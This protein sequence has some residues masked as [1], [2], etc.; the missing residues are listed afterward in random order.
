MKHAERRLRAKKIIAYLKNKYPKAKSEL[1]YKTPY[2]FVTAVILSARCTD[3]AVNK[4]TA[5]LFKKYKTVRNF[6]DANP[7]LFTKE[8]SSIPFYNNKTKFIIRA[9]KEILLRYDGIVPRT[10]SEL[11]ALPGIG[12][13]TA[14]VILGELYDMWDGIA[15]DTHVKRFARRFD[16]TD[17]TDPTKISKD[18]EILIPKKDWKYVNAGMVL[19]GRYVC[20]AR[21]H[22]CREHPLTK[23]WQPVANRWSHSN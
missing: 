14:N 23:L 17:N 11:V 2:Q 10:V 1:Q 18:L 16:L 6:A 3:K 20:T 22:N 9:A 5:A 15:T 8:I 21:P 19:Y 12:Y 13:K 4:V 7:N